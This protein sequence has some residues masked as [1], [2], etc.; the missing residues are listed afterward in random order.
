MQTGGWCKASHASGSHCQDSGCQGF[1]LGL[2][3]SEPVLRKMTKGMGTR[4]R[5][6]TTWHP[7]Q[8]ARRLPAQIDLVQ[9]AANLG[10]VE[11][12]QDR[13]RLHRAGEGTPVGAER[14]EIP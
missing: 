14:S 10:D 7:S 5:V 6:R 2:E 8:D 9:A 4:V 11:E 12:V 1:G 13:E 3:S